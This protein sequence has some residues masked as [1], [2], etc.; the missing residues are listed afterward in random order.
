MSCT[1]TCS[2][3]GTY[4]AIPVEGGE[5][6]A[7]LCREALSDCQTRCFTDTRSCMGGCNGEPLAMTSPLSG[8][9]ATLER[10]CDQNGCCGM[11]LRCCRNPF[12]PSFAHPSWLCCNQ[13]YRQ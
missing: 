5:A 2:N 9:E 10:C 11:Y 12:W 8:S 6:T 1:C 4:P 3:S 7:P 13:L